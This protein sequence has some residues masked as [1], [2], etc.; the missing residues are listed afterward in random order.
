MAIMKHNYLFGLV[1]M[2]AIELLSGCKTNYRATGEITGKSVDFV[3]DSKLAQWMIEKPDHPRVVQLFDQF[4]NKPLNTSTLSEIADQ[5]SMD[6]SSLYFIYRNYQIEQNKQIIDVFTAMIAK[7][8]TLNFHHRVQ[9]L[10]KYTFVFVPGFFYKSFPFSGAD[11][12]AQRHFMDKYKIPHYFIETGE[13]DS[14]TFNAN[15]IKTEINKISRETDNIILVSAS[16]GGL[17]TFNVLGKMMTEDEMKPIKAWVSV[18]GIIRG[19]PVKSIYKNFPYNIITPILLKIN[20]IDPKPYMDLDSERR[21]R[22]SN[23]I[24]LPHNLVIIHYMGVPMHSNVNKQ[25]K[26]R[27]DLMKRFGP[28]DGSC[29]IT[30][31]ITDDGLTIADPGLDHY[32]KDKN[33]MQK[34]ISL[35]EIAVMEIEKKTVGSTITAR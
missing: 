32:L 24:H 7:E 30:E 12:E 4:K 3:V 19:C 15:I 31:Q 9:K 1:M 22:E 17:E 21:I 10:R 13:S 29:P 34:T 23:S 6:V 2:I 18:C 26:F 16:K 35:C 20:K 33:I 14:T 28:N 25:I 11:F 8:D 27:Y 5:Y